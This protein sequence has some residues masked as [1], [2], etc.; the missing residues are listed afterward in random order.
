MKKFLLLPLLMLSQL[1]WAQS[2][3]K[4]GFDL[5]EAGNFAQGA[6][7]FK[8]YLDTKDSTNRTALL[9]YGRGIGLSGNV[10]E[11]QRVFQKLQQRYAD[12]F[13]IGLN[14]AESLMWAKQYAEAKTYYEKLLTQQPTN[15][16][17][18]LGYANALSSLHSYRQALT[19]VERANL[20]QAG[21]A[22]ARISR[23]YIKLGLADQ[24]SKNQQY[25][26]A[27]Q[28]LESILQDFPN[29]KDALFAKAQIL[30]VQERYADAQRVYQIL[31]GKP[32][33]QTNAYLGLS[34]L[35][36]L[37]KKKQQALTYAN[38]AIAASQGY[39][40]R[41]LKAQL[42]RVSAL[43]WNE[44]FKPAFALL[45][46]LDKA[47]PNSVDITVSRAT[48]SVWNKQYAR[49]AEL[50]QQALQVKPASFDGNLGYADARH[51]EGND[52]EAYRYVRKTLEY[53][54]NQLDATN[55]MQR[56]DLA[57]KPTVTTH[58]FVSSDNGNNVSTNYY[59]NGAFDLSTN[60]RV[61]VG[62]RERYVGTVSEGK[63]ANVK[64]MTAGFRTRL[65][66]CWTMSGNAGLI[67]LQ[68]DSTVSHLNVNI[69]NEFKIG[70][71]Q[72]ADI[73]YNRDAQNFT[74]GLVG[75]NITYHNL[76]GTYNLATPFKLG[77]YSQYI[78]TL[79]SDN[80]QQKSLF[81]SLY[82]DLKYAPV[83]KAGVNVQMMSFQKQLPEIYFSPSQFISVESFFHIENLTMPKQKLLYQVSLAGGLQHIEQESWQPTYRVSLQTGYRPSK[84]IEVMAYVLKSNIA[85]ST[86]TGYSYSEAGIKG[87][88]VIVK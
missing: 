86:V 37:Q 1:A 69:V 22:N 14:W 54:P 20:I 68:K 70:R 16:A 42:G 24:L 62:Y 51:A 64:T 58:A 19:Y 50:Y 18:M 5:L 88:W 44:K 25:G 8:T 6:S 7:F 46:S 78:H 76:I 17:A 60:F 35:S 73:R 59:V 40:D 49:G 77:F 74:A 43:G 47:Y 61:N 41:Q 2:E 4:P 26:E 12:D 39:P 36:F 13:E 10:P 52:A 45:D 29:D 27:A 23:K 57:H 48:L 11:A 33:N 3:L 87:R 9:C 66:S 63:N 65:A 55:F 85:T 32:E 79:Y 82:Y 15:F 53:Y 34:Y 75:Y 30:V 21:N 56:L 80:N 67:T 83:I 71:Y 84:N 31:V 28:L 81:A 38:Q 72:M